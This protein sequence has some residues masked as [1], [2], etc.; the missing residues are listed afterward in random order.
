MLY[1]IHQQ[2]TQPKEQTM[3][4]QKFEFNTLAM[5]TRFTERAIKP[6]DIILGDNGLFWVVTLA[7]GERLVRAG[8]ERAE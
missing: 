2:G 6:M 1:I 7:D 5:A 3:T 8:Y 4:I